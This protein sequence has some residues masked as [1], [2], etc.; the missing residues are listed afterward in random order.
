MI[1]LKPLSQ[2]D[3]AW[4]KKVLGHNTNSKYSVGGYGCLITCLAMA[5]N[6]YE[7]RTDPG[8]LNEKLKEIGGFVN[9]GYYVWDSLTRIYPEILEKRRITPIPLNLNQV[10]EIKGWLDKG[11][12]VMIM[13]DMYPETAPVD[14]HFV[15]LIGYSNND[16]T[17][18]DP[19]TGNIC[20]L[21]EYLGKFAKTFEQCVEQYIGLINDPPDSFLDSVSDPS[22]VE[23]LKDKI[24]S[25]ETNLVASRATEVRLMDK[26]HKMDKTYAD[27]KEIY[28]K[29]VKELADQRDKC[30]KDY[31]EFKINVELQNTEYENTIKGLRIIKEEGGAEV[32]KNILWE[33]IKDPLR[34][35]VLGVI[36]F[37]IAYFTELPFEWAGFVTL[38]LKGLDRWLH[39]VGKATKDEKLILGLTRF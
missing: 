9:G 17:I 12:P 5:A 7:R 23:L 15:L 14:M 36:P 8:K 10:S 6:W 21:S 35:L 33:S 4:T 11:H 20:S 22:E 26:I 34:L 37:A 29:E 18:A 31:A 2:R 32:D 30:Q 13:V 27:L 16:W 25:I 38:I 19:W 3:P 24:E 39:N 1:K 28:A